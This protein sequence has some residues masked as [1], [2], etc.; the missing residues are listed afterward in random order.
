MFRRGQV[1][2]V[3]PGRQYRP[4]VAGLMVTTAR[5]LTVGQDAH[6]IP[7]VYFEITMGAPSSSH[8]VQE[9]R[10]LSLESF[11]ALYPQPVAV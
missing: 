1:E 9:N 6:G 3:Q 4:L 10:V 11:T 5:V 8:V 2:A 7:H